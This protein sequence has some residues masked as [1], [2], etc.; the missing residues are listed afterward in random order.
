MKFFHSR[1]KL[2]SAILRSKCCFISLLVFA[3]LIRVRIA[4]NAKRF[5]HGFVISVCVHNSPGLPTRMNKNK[6]S[7]GSVVVSLIL[8]ISRVLSGLRVILPTSEFDKK[9]SNFIAASRT[10][11]TPEAIK[12]SK[13]LPKNGLS[14][15]LPCC[16]EPKPEIEFFVRNLLYLPRRTK[17]KQ[18]RTENVHLADMYGLVLSHAVV[19]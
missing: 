6:R 2:R 17:N 18:K 14:L 1:R 7:T 5:P 13:S 3:N 9:H 12:F 11:R 10:F 15:E 4:S 16:Q 19:F 8:I